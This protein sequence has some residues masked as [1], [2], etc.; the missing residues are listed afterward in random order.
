MRK[1]SEGRKLLYNTVMLY[2]LTGSNYLFGLVT[3][4]YLTR[5]LGPEIYGHIGFGS[6]FETIVQLVLDFGFILSGTMEVAK[7]QADK[8]KVQRTASAV[9]AA[10]LMLVIPTIVVVG[11]ICLTVDRFASE[12][13]LF[14]LYSCYAICNALMPDFLYRG[15]EH[16]KTITVR[17]VSIKLFF[18]ICIY[19]FVKGPEQYI[20]VPLFYYLGSLGGLIA[21][22]MHQYSVM[23][24]RFVKVTF[25]EAVYQLGQSFMFFLSRVAG[26]VF[27]SL[28]MLILGFI[29]PTGPTPGYYSTA[30]SIIS[31]GRNA[32]TPVTGSLFPHIVR[33]KNFKLLFRVAAVG[34]LLLCSACLLVGIFAEPLCIFLFGA[35]YAGSAVL[36][37]I[38][39]PL[40]PISLVT[41]LFGWSAL[42]ALGLERFTNYSVYIASVFQ[43]A[44]LGLLYISG[45]LDAVSICVIT[46]ASEVIVLLIRTGV[47]MWGLKHQQPSESNAQA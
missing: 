23:K 9:L 22:Y 31:A 37:R 20:L 27:S 33:T 14:I 17:S 19:L 3:I 25:E 34:E 16:M 8:D 5:T 7:Y 45:R 2:L 43:L 46:L 13:L 18:L 36:L 24:I 1:Q 39:L 35:D 41:Y 4:P 30:N 11:I 15:L 29:Y 26:Q 38:I 32:V 6:A 10:K 47:M 28:N 42:G 44:A 12:P 21:V 40:I